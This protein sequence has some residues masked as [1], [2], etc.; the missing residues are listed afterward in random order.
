MAGKKGKSSDKAGNNKL[1]NDVVPDERL[2]AIVLTDSF[3]TRFMP[4]TAVKPRCLLPLANVPLIEYTLEFLAKAGASEVYL[5]CA[6]H[7]EQ[8]SEYIEQ[9]KWNQPWSPFRVSTIMSLESRSVGDAMRDLDNRGIVT[10]D[11][12]LVSGDL[13]TNMEFDKAL[14]FH[15]KRKAED[16]DHI[17][18]MCLSRASQLFRSRCHE[19][20]AFILDKS[21][22]KCLYYQDIP[23]ENSKLKNAIAIDPELLEDVDEFKIRNDLVDCHVDICSPHVPAIFQE[24]FDY[25]F[26]RRDFVKGVLTSDLLKKSIY[27][28]ITDDYAARVESWQTYDAISQDF[29]ARWCYPMVLNSNLLDD[30][31]YSYES[32][33]IYKEKDVVLAQS[34]KIGKCTG[35]G[36][37]SK[38]GEGTSIENSVIGRNCH[39]KE[40]IVIKNSF[41]WDN[42]T[43][44]S[45]SVVEHALVASNVS[46]GSGV[47]LMDG[48]VIGFNVSI[49]DNMTIP[50]GTRLSDTYVHKPVSQFLDSEPYSDDEVEESEANPDNALPALALVGANGVGY[51]Y[52]SDDAHD[53]DE[54]SS[55]V[56]NGTN[57]LT[58]RFD[59]LYLSDNSISSMSAKHK[60]KRRSSTNSTAAANG[61]DDEYYEE[62]MDEDED[63]E[64]FAAEAIATVERAMENNHDIDTALLELNTLRMS[65]NVTYQEVRSA[66]VVA[67]L[68]RVY[69][70]IATQTLGAKDAL[71]KV[72]GQWGPLFK[73]QAFDQ[74]EYV[75]LANLILEKTVAQRFEKP[76]FI[77]FTA[78]TFL[79]D[80]DILDEDAVDAWWSQV[81]QDPKY[82][83][84]K[85][86]IAKWI[87]WLRTADEQS[88]S[89]EGSEES[90]SE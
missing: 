40:N 67:L 43:I 48:C 85:V 1:K 64:D 68:R 56:F 82:D 65:I 73:R 57:A 17:V 66:T 32:E 89:E 18:T 62:D 16:K 33:H 80:Q 81:S 53:D 6:S 45:D 37:G 58:H 27:A 23:L 72:F 61:R 31:T 30:Q 38:I 49:D 14:D 70:F 13:V 42:V 36:S 47:V 44:G 63:E 83:Q 4:L 76:E 60:K 79:Y 77:V 39:I 19:P 20:A 86:L 51:V 24:N 90:D 3:E 11:F 25:Q 88:S 22:D 41:I 75:D 87:E 74:D 84:A 21:N 46:I 9:S 28:F 71:L 69:H 10:G 8:M 2:Q 50:V 35:I 59:D 12:I 34:C 26:L 78:L 7:A 15:R 52:E 54:D 55:V 29:I 5:M